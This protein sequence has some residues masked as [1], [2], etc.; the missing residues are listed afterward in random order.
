MDVMD[1]SVKTPGPASATVKSAQRVLEVL[2][3]FAERQ[4]AATVT[5]VATALGYPQSSTSMLLASLESLGYLQQDRTTRTF[6]PTLRVMLLGTWLHDGLFAEGSL[7]AS[8]ERLRLSTRSAV[9]IGLRQGVHVRFILSL[10]SAHPNALHYPVGVIR[11]VCRSAAGKALLA[12][13]TDAEVARIARRA[14][15]EAADPVD[16]VEVKAL[17]DEIRQCRAQGWAESSDYPKPGRVTLAIQV[18]PMHGQPA[19][20]IAL[21]ARKDTIETRRPV[22]LAALAQASESLQHRSGH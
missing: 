1:A 16:R 2:E 22:L 6:H 8:M 12:R 4:S 20:A 11:P 17:L 10:P 13:E 3:L 19:M 21:G 5:E 18:P 9:L 7:L 15:A 14:N